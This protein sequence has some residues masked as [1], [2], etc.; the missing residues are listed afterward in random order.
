[1]ALRRAAGRRPGTWLALAAAA[2][3]FQRIGSHLDATGRTIYTD[4]NMDVRDG[5]I[6]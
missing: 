4:M 2:S 3:F 5:L 6:R 1:M